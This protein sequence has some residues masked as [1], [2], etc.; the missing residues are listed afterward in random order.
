MVDVGVHPQTH[1]LDGALRLQLHQPRDEAVGGRRSGKGALNRVRV[2]DAQRVQAAQPHA[3][4]ALRV[5]FPRPGRGVVGQQAALLQRNGEGRP[6]LWPQA[7]DMAEGA[8]PPDHLAGLG[9]DDRAAAQGRCGEGVAQ[10]VLGITVQWGGVEVNDPRLQCRVHRRIHLRELDG[11]GAV[12][13][14]GAATEDDVGRI[15]RPTVDE[16]EFCPAAGGGQVQI[17]DLISTRG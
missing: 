9:H 6:R 12:G 7:G 5:G 10:P 16:V 3:L 13:H 1:V 8:Q 11:A 4:A 2:V 15:D 17:R 14:D